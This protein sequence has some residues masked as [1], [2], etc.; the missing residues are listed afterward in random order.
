[1][2]ALSFKDKV[3]LV[4][5]GTKGIGLATSL[6]FASLGANC[7]ITYKVDSD[8]SEKI[9]N[10][11]KD[12]GYVEPLIIQ[13]DVSQDEDID[14]LL[15]KIKENYSLV[16]I[17]ISNVAF[18]ALTK[19]I[20]DYRERDF[21]K[22][23]DY[24]VWPLVGITKSLKK[25]F[26]RYPRYIVGLSSNGPNYYHNN[27]DFVATAKSIMEQLIKYMSYRLKEYNVNVNILRTSFVDTESFSMTF[28]E[29]FKKFGEKFYKKFSMFMQPEDV[30]NGVLMLCSGLMD[31]LKGQ[32]LLLD[33]GATFMDNTMGYYHNM[34]EL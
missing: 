3:V 27:Y 28:G 10:L 20:T 30:A 8:N 18:A 14:F 9:K 25:V 12:R 32:V 1:M 4:T 17:F 21:F 6:A 15:M 19:N 5:G 16:D 31:G 2:N 11:F 7:V 22:G 34:I 13:S 23:I 33:N 24:S 26:K 29:G